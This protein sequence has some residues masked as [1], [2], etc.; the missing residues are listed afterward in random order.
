[1]KIIIQNEK[2][3]F[4][5]SYDERNVPKTAGFRW[6]SKAKDWWTA[7]PRIAARLIDVVEMTDDVRAAIIGGI[8][9]KVETAELSRAVDAEVNTPCN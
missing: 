5:G 7:D 2:F 1:M 9:E 6:D 3:V 8:D 4:Q